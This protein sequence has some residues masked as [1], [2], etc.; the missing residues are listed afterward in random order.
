MTPVQDGPSLDLSVIIITLNEERH[1]ERCLVSLPPGV[2]LIVLDSGSEDA[3][4]AIARRHGAR[5]LHRAF[6]TYAEQKNAALALATRSWVLSVDADEELTPALRESLALAIGKA[7][8][9]TRAV[10]YKVRRRLV[11]MGRRMRFGKTSDRPLRLFRKESGQFANAIHERL[12]LSPEVAVAVLQGDLLHYSYDDISDYFVRFNAY[13]TRI[14]VQHAENA[15][16]SP[17]LA[18]LLMRP[19]LEFCGRYFLRLGFLDGYPG[20]C[21]ALFSSLYAFVKYA[22]L[23]ELREVQGCAF[24]TSAPI[25]GIAPSAN[26]PSVPPAP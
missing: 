5:C 26:M 3:T 18:S 15:R 16:G 21:Y 23:K 17:T 7:K 8:E 13:T 22:K 12:V 4:C 9:Q 2:E 24:G 6:T 10:A 25:A 1:L 11:F 20:Y 14:A 19:W